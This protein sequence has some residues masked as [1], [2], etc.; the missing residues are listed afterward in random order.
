MPTEADFAG[1]VRDRARWRSVTWRGCLLI[2]FLTAIWHWPVGA[3]YVEVAPSFDCA[4]ASLPTERTICTDPALAR[5]DAEFAVYYQDNLE[6]AATFRATAMGQTLRR[7]ERDFLG[8]RNRCGSRKW[9]IEREYLYQDLRIA[10]MSGEPHRPR[11]PMRIYVNHYVGAYIGSWI[12]AGAR[13]LF[14]ETHQRLAGPR[15]VSV[16]GRGARNTNRSD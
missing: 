11:A 7:A 13:G 5:I 2:V 8:A 16:N 12:S 4:R 9:C 15:A 3:Q 1:S 6:V 14:A 10:D